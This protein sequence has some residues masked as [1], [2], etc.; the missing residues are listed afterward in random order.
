MSVNRKIVIRILLLIAELIEQ[1][2]DTRK[3]LVHLR[4]HISYET[5]RLG[6]EAPHA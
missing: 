4:N 2:R 3:E 1:D 6:V 5:A